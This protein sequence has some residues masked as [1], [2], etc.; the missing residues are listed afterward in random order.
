MIISIA[1]HIGG[2]TIRDTRFTIRPACYNALNYGQ[3]ISHLFAA[4]QEHPR[5]CNRN[6]GA[7]Y[8]Y[9]YKH[10][11][12][13]CGP[14]QVPQ[15]FITLINSTFGISRATCILRYFEHYRQ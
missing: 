11:E 4:Y 3:I 12:R 9:C 13:L 6:M 8:G 10:R 5:S 1:D 14:Y 7:Y 2:F 15:Q